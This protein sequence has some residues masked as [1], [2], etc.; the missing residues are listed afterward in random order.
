VP[1]R[2]QFTFNG[3]LADRH[4]MDFYEAGRFQYGAARL[5]V[6]LDQFRR[7]GRFADR[8]TPE[9]NTRIVI[10]AQRPGSFEFLVLAPIA[11]QM[12]EAF[13]QAPVSL[14]WSYVADRIF[15]SASQENIREAL[16]TQRE[17]VGVFER[18]IAEHGEQQRRTLDL[19]EDR[20]AR[21][22]QLSA[23]NA[24]L[25]ERLLTETERRAYLEG[26]RDTL[27]RIS[28][29]QDAKLV[30]MAAPL[31]KDMGVALRNSASTLS[32]RG[33]EQEVERRLVFANKQMTREIETTR[34]DDETTLILVHIVQYNTETGWG[35]L[36]MR[37]HVGLLPFNVPSDR[38][39]DL[40]T[41]LLAAMDED[42]TYIE[43]IFI[44]TPR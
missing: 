40:Q 36:R 29:E 44:R 12:A 7:T 8:V 41:A 33:Q 18:E 24:Q 19:L 23:E 37:E 22:D 27:Q 10:E 28:A 9:N 5:M 38:K 17:L 4:L 34:V 15:K 1:E 13:V 39:R 30:S 32:I 25:R 42:Q 35:R 14:M 43:C 3:E 2:I 11:A 31:L 6:K 20:I 21:G 16:A 26:E